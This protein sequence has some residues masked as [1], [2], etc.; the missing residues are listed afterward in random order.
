VAVGGTGVAVGNGV[1]VGAAVDVGGTGVAVGA[2]VAVG[3]TGVTVGT[4]VDVG[5]MGVAVGIAV[6]VAATVVPAT[7]VC[8]GV[9][10]GIAVACAATGVG[11]ETSAPQAARALLNTTKIIARNRY[12]FDFRLFIVKFVPLTFSKPA[13]SGRKAGAQPHPLAL[14][15]YDATRRL[16]SLKQH[17]S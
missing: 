11:T 4:G 13:F 1:D 6:A 17:I 14:S 5:G 8:T 7:V 9:C 2:R 16:P 10:E 12:F 3:G 15:V